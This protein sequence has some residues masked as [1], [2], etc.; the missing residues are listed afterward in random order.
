MPTMPVTTTATT[1][2]VVVLS[3]LSVEVSAEVVVPF[4]TGGGDGGD[5]VTF[6]TCNAVNS[7]TAN[8]PPEAVML[9]SSIAIAAFAFGSP[10]VSPGR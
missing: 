7:P 4:M 3:V 6:T 9:V 1:M 8:L 2:I 10:V 5:G